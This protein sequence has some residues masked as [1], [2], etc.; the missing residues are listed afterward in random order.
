MDITPTAD[1]KGLQRLKLE[2][3][4]QTVKPIR[5]VEDYPRIAGDAQQPLKPAPPHQERRHQPRRQEERRQ[6]EETTPYDTRARQE[7]RQQHRRSE[8]KL[9]TPQ[10]LGSPPHIDEQV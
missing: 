9:G 10:K 6:A 1:D 7:R 8:D 2:Q 5:P 3:Q 4:D